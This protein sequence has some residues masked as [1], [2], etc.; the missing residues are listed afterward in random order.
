MRDELRLL[1]LMA[2]VYLCSLLYATGVFVAAVVTHNDAAR[3]LV[4]SAV[5]LG[6]FGYYL[7]MMEPP[8]WLVNTVC[9][10]SIIWAIAAGIALL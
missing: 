9:W 5:G 1:A 10:A 3:N 2:G 4:L 7:Q 8:S 6:A